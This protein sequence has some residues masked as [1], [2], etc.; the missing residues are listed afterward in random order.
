[1]EVRDTKSKM[2]NRLW[3][4]SLIVIGITTVII[5]VSSIIGIELSDIVQGILGV[6]DLISLPALA[7]TTIYKIKNKV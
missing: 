4:V 3:A 2:I 6:I 7:L 1:M 5:S